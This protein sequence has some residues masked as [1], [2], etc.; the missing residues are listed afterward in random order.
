MITYIETSE[1][2]LFYNDQNE[3]VAKYHIKDE[4]LKIY[5]VMSIEEFREINMI[6][7]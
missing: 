7:K 1:K 2:I 4:N 5:G 3:L 6:L